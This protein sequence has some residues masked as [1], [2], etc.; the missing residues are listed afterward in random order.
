M[1]PHPALFARLVVVVPGKV[2]V[3]VRPRLALIAAAVAAHDL[4]LLIVLVPA[5]RLRRRCQW[6]RH[7]RHRRH[8]C[9]CRQRRHRRP[10]RGAGLLE[11]REFRRPGQRRLDAGGEQ[12]DLL[13]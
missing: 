9:H 13:R 12:A 8:R 7:R 1:L 6:R 5:Q 10:G 3:V 4:G 2:D 11:R